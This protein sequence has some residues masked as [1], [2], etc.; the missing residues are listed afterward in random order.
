MTTGEKKLSESLKRV[1]SDRPI[2]LRN[3]HCAY[4]N[5][6]LSDEN[7]T[8][9]H[10][11][12]RRF[13]PKGKLESQWNLIVAACEACNSRKS[14]LE[15]DISAITMLPDLAGSF[16]HDDEAAIRDAQNK[17]KKSYSRRTKQAVAQSQENIKIEAPFAEGV[18]FTF[19]MTGPAQ[20]DEDRVYELAR[21]Q[22][23]AFFYWITY[24]EVTR[25]GG[26]WPGGFYPLMVVR[27]SDWGNEV[28]KAF[29]DTVVDWEPRVFGCNADGFFKVAVRRHPD[30]ECWSWALEWNHSTRVVGFL[31]DRAAAEKIVAPFPKLEMQTLEEAPGRYIRFRVEK[32]LAEKDD[33]LFY[34]DDEMEDTA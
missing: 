8:R 21:L 20:V 26:F 27:R 7:E 25:R 1:R 30:A 28:I 14:D 18:K 23:T 12:G 22:L 6:P 11:V 16:G 3:V 4:C 19:S 9:E 32:A 29:A 33:R 2:R 13:V 17:A 24:N 15:D 5:I 34:L 10:V 31:G